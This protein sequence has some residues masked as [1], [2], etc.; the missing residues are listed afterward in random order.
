MH[1]LLLIFCRLC[2]NFNNYFIMINKIYSLFVFSLAACLSPC[3]AGDPSAAQE[4][5]PALNDAAHLAPVAA[6]TG[7]ESLESG[8]SR[9]G[10]AKAT[11]SA[12][13]AAAQSGQMIILES[14]THAWGGSVSG[15]TDTIRPNG[16]AIIRGAR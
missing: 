7:E 9:V 1:K 3:F 8:M 10:P 15:K 14:G 2:T 16:A 6:M 4:R 12:A 5:H 11:I 13:L